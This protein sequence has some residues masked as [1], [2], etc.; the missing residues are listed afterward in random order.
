VTYL[1]ITAGKY[2]VRKHPA[3]GAPAHDSYCFLG[4][5]NSAGGVTL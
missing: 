5:D 4:M 1:Y 3:T 2:R